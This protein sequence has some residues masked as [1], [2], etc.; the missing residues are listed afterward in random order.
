[1]LETDLKGRA[2]SRENQE[3]PKFHSGGKDSKNKRL[4]RKFLKTILV[5]EF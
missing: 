5:I 1:M 2:S 3:K 4:K